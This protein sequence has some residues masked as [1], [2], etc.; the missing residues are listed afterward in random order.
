MLITGKLYTIPNDVLIDHFWKTNYS[1][2]NN[3]KHLKILLFVNL[4]STGEYLRTYRFLCNN[5]ITIAH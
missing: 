5:K 3:T 2:V 1:R 4:G